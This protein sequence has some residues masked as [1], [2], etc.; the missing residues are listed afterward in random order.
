MLYL[1]C[2]SSF[3][4]RL[5]PFTSSK[6][7]S[8]SDQSHCKPSHQPASPHTQQTKQLNTYSAAPFNGGSTIFT[9]FFTPGSTFAAPRCTPGPTRANPRFHRGPHFAACAASRSSAPGTKKRRGAAEA[10]PATPTRRPVERVTERALGI[11]IAIA[12]RVF[13]WTNWWRR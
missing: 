6:P 9:P 2:K 13:D 11:M 1:L 10:V 4:I 12:C 7:S 8:Y 5:I 3:P